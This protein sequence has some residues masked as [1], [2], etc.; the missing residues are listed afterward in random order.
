MVRVGHQNLVLSYEGPIHQPGNI[1]IYAPG[2]K[3]LMLVDVIFPG[4]SPFNDLALAK[5][6]PRF[7]A[8]H[9]KILTFDFTTFVGGHLNRLGTRADVEESQRYTLDIKANAKAACL[10]RRCTPFLA[11]CRPMPPCPW[12]FTMPSGPLPFTW[13]RWPVNVPTGPWTPC[14]RRRAPTGGGALGPPISIL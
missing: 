11:S 14:S 4:W 5:D 3:T 6:V 12:G 7:V 1:F 13:I 8:A 2:Q 10:I 9:E